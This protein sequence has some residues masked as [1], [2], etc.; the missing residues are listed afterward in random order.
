MRRF[1]YNR[2]LLLAIA[3]GLIA[4]LVIAGQRH[5]IEIHNSQ[6]DMAMDYD[7]LRNL[8]EREGLEFDE[9]LK[10]FKAAGITSLAV[11]D[12]TFEKLT[13]GGKVI[14]V[15]GSDI[16]ANYHSGALNSILW[17]Q[18]VDLGA[19]DP[20]R[21]YIIG[22]NLESYEE[23]KADLI[24]RLGAERVKSFAV[25]D[26]EVLEVKAQFGAFMSMPIG[27][28]TAELETAKNAGFLILAR[29][30]N[31]QKCTAEDVR[32]VFDRLDGYPISEI[33][34]D[35][36]EILGADDC[37]DVTAAE[38]RKRGLILGVIEHTSQLQFYPQAGMQ[39]LAAKIGYNKIARLYAVPRDEQ[40]RLQIDTLVNRWATTDRERN[41]RIN[42]LR[43]YE[44][45]AP[46][47][48]LLETNLKYVR[49][50]RDKLKT[51]GY[52]FGR[53]DTFESYYPHKILRVLVVVGVM[54]ALVLYLSLISRRFNANPQSQVAIFAVLA[55]AAAIPILM[56]AGGKVRLLAALMSANLFPALAVIWQ[57]DRLRFMR[58]ADRDRL[59]TAQVVLAAVLALIVTSVLSMIGAA[60]LSGALS[61]VEFFLEFQI[62]RGIKLT[63]IL[64]L[65]LVGFAFLQRFTVVDEVRLNV[66]AVEQLREILDMRVTVKALLGIFA[67][68]AAFVVLIARSGHT[69]GMPVSGAEIQIRSALEQMFYARP[70]SKEIFIGH[71]AFVLA[72]AA[73]L[74]S[75]PKS[76]CCVLTLLA[77]VGQSSMVET[78]AHMRTP[79]LMSFL[80]GVDGV[81]PGAAIGAVL[82]LL[83]NFVWRFEQMESE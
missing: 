46:G 26:A 44:K 6:V 4:S 11:Y 7:S 10:Q 74:R 1:L 13:R 24:R 49:E 55:V 39:E 48:T 61:D 21:T 66:P 70:R 37:V 71:P 12:T 28:P 8:A 40:P 69:A 19:I 79:V 22:R 34:F 82:V 5:A 80:R 81:L 45:A 59:S 78:F 27:I 23:A 18:A 67:V 73:F 43:T 41:I 62:F 17:R 77:T 36:P 3:A 35:G 63:F 68:V 29:P 31:F 60:Y 50:T 72:I 15:Y 76:V 42:L 33:V 57:L 58:A 54:A 14:A 51:Y 30:F 64:P 9:V 65:I 38:F 20:T 25:G 83:I 52:T 16:I 2:I 32:A 53:A 56:G 75:F 47:M